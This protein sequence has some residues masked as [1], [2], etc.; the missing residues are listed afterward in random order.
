MS[1]KRLKR[2][3]NQVIIVGKTKGS[4]WR[5]SKNFEI[6]VYYTPVKNKIMIIN[7]EGVDLDH[8]KLFLN[9]SVGDDSELVYEWIEK[10]GHEIVF[11]RNRLQN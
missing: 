11:Q 8:P 10:H 3:L 6:Q 2:L 1:Y 5:K 9:F 7:I 4:F